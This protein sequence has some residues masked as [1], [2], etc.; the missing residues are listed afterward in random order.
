MHSSQLD[1]CKKPQT[2]KMAKPTYLWPNN[3]HKAKQDLHSSAQGQLANQSCTAVSSPD[4]KS[5]L[6]AQPNILHRFMLIS[7]VIKM[8]YVTLQ[9]RTLASSPYTQ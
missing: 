6:Y 2:A 3:F 8:V 7:M 1:V 5:K 9:S 4:I